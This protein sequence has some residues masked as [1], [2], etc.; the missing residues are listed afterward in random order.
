MRPDIPHFSRLSNPSLVS[1]WVRRPVQMPAVLRRGGA[2][3]PHFC[4]SCRT[5]R[6]RLTRFSP[7][8]TRRPWTL[9][10][11]QSASKGPCARTIPEPA[12]NIS[13]HLP[14]P[15]GLC[16]GMQVLGHCVTLFVTTA[17]W[18]WCVAGASDHV[19]I[20]PRSYFFLTHCGT[21]HS[22]HV[23]VYLSLS[24]SVCV[25]ARMCVCV[26]ARMCVC[27]HVHHQRQKC[28]T[29]ADTCKKK[30]CGLLTLASHW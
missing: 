17:H 22:I 29:P 19:F 10:P 26:C 14:T 6:K 18:L 12:K 21:C 23:C 3:L 9:R 24:L 5:P 30:F 27:M 16:G 25:R 15:A 13:S 28:L 11:A 8:C 2:S 7:L 1:R 20:S 4:L